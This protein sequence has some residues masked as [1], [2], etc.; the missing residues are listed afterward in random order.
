[1]RAIVA[2][3][4]GF[5]RLSWRGLGIATRVATT[6]KLRVFGVVRIETQFSRV[7]DNDGR[8]ARFALLVRVAF[9]VPTFWLLLWES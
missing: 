6:D 4:V 3:F 2:T 9:A 8:I 5:F 7:P 1:M